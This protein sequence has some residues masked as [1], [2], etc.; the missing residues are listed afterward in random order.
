[1]EWVLTQTPSL[2][3]WVH[4]YPKILL[5]YQGHNRGSETWVP[6]GSE[7]FYLEPRVDFLNFSCLVFEF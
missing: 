5:V 1:M 2:I 7:P 3:G 4:R 6:P